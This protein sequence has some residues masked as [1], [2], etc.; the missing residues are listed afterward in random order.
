[1]VDEPD[2]IDHELSHQKLGLAF[3]RAHQ[4]VNE[5]AS[6]YKETGN[7]VFMWNAIAA[8]TDPAIIGVLF[9]L[10]EPVREYLHTAALG[11]RN[12]AVGPPRK[13]EREMIKALSLTKDKQGHSV[14]KN[15]ARVQS[16]EMLLGVYAALAFK[17]GSSR[18]YDMIAKAQHVDVSSLRKKLTE[19][20][21]LANK[22]RRSAGLG[23]IT[24]SY[25][26]DSLRDV[27][28]E[29]LPD[30]ALIGGFVEGAPETFWRK[31]ST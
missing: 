7:P 25:I 22:I 6:R 27:N 28:G 30:G 14:A 23:Q 10:P 15:Y 19:G 17:H 20:R 1:M 8:M 29:L 31:N 9:P 21:K 4:L 16:I 18:A 13:F 24:A 26:P 5:A 11:V 2:P 3:L 12:A